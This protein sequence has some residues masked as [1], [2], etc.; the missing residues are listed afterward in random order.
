MVTLIITDIMQFSVI[1]PIF[2]S[3]STIARCL[4]TFLAQ[5]A[6][7]DLEILCIGDKI[8]DPSHA[9]VEEYARKHP[10]VVHLHLQD[11]RGQGGARNVGLSLAHG[12]YIMFADADDYVEPNILATCADALRQF[13]ADFICVGFDRASVSGKRYSY[14]QAVPE[15]TPV[16]VT[17]ENLARLAFI[18]PAPWGKL[19]RRE[20]IGDCRFPENPASAYEDLIFFLSLCPH[21]RRYVLLPDILY[22]YIVHDKSSITSASPE[23]TRIFRKDLIT[24]RRNFETD[25]LP[26]PY[27]NLL[28][29]AAFI[30]VG[31]ADAHRMAENPS[32]SLRGFCTKAKEFLQAHFPGWRRI[33][34]RPYGRFTLRCAAVWF[35]KHAYRLGLFWLFIRLYNRMIKTLHMD[36]KW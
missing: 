7:D 23:K 35:A 22:H 26:A 5:S 11:G 8:E 4:D 18:Y 28:D 3:H 15:T 27:F 34:L 36:V 6:S 1:I 33:P 12:D 10:G 24:L 2:H 30:H 17:P 16:D 25:E 21:I 31:I 9:I 14:E 29:T 20:V 32:V 19:F 13:N